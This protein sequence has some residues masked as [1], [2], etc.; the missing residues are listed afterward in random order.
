MR[1]NP[2]QTTKILS[3]LKPKCEIEGKTI[4]K[5]KEINHPTLYYPN[6]ILTLNA[7]TPDLGDESNDG[8]GSYL[9]QFLQ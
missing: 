7:K 5:L 2:K 6:P 8:I 3:D 4:K 1:H 9:M